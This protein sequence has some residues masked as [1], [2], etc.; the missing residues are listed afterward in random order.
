MKRLVE[1]TIKTTFKIKARLDA[2]KSSYLFNN[3]A[4]PNYAKI[5][6]MLPFKFPIKKLFGILCSYTKFNFF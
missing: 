3:I 1:I 2:K 5:I 6:R 4:C